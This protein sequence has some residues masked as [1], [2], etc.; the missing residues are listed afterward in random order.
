[1][2]AYE[3]VASRARVARARSRSSSCS[4]RMRRK[5]G[6]SVVSVRAGRISSAVDASTMTAGKSP[7]DRIRATDWDYPPQR[8]PTSGM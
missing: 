3:D 1:M 6:A 4:A 2:G 8:A 5:A 7:R